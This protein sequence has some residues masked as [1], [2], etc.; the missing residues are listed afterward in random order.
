MKIAGVMATRTQ[1]KAKLKTVSKEEFFEL[2]EFLCNYA[3]ST[4][5][6]L[7]DQVIPPH[8]IIP[9]ILDRAD[10]SPPLGHALD[11]HLGLPTEATKPRRLQM[12]ILLVAIMALIATVAIPLCTNR[13][14]EPTIKRTADAP[15]RSR[16]PSTTPTTHAGS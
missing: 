14:A 15:M 12:L 9:R 11:T 16:E 7:S 2:V 5:R 10:A 6:G 13:H 1:R 4:W 3:P 8:K